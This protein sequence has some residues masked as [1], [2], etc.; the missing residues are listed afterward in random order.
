MEA[1]AGGAAL[2]LG[3][4][5]QL[6]HPAIEAEC[7]DSSTALVCVW[8]CLLHCL[9]EQCLCARAFSSSAQKGKGSLDVENTE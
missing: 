3:E 5:F 6:P 2:V 4:S 8:S 1:G 9:E 7:L